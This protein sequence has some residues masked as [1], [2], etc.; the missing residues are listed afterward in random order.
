[1]EQAESNTAITLIS[2]QGNLDASNYKELIASGK[3]ALV[4]GAEHLI[5]D[6][7]DMPFM[8]SSGLV[9]LHSISLLLRGEKPV[10]PEHGWE[11]FHAIA[12]D[13]DSEAQ[14]K[15][16]LVNQ[17]PQ[18]VRTL[19]VAGMKEFFEFHT[20]LDSAVASFI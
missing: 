15:I 16:T 3:Q 13:R 1:M 9:A 17:Q 10:D 19:E 2:V 8:S 14:K 5:I 20:D 12:R 6:M 11:A 4:E 18:I 7:S